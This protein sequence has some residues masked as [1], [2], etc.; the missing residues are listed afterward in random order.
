MTGGFLH[1]PLWVPYEIYMRTDYI[2][3]WKAIEDKNGFTAAQA[4]MNMP[5]SFL[6]LFYLY[7]IYSRG[8][9]LEAACGGAKSRFLA[10]RYVA[11]QAGAL[12]V[13]I[14]FTA[15]V[16]TCSKT[17]LY[18]MLHLSYMQN[19]TVTHTHRTQ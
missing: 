19:L 2:Y 13:L 11:G 14:G 9:Q 8:T 6:Y 17:L 3:G 5:E 12:A 1:W 16:M 15:A 10:Q 18:G 7:I 4:S